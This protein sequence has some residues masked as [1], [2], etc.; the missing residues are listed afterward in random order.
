MPLPKLQLALSK[1]IAGL[2]ARDRTIDTLRSQLKASASCTPPLPTSFTPPA[3]PR[4][5][6]LEV[7]KWANDA[8]HC[9]T[10]AEARAKATNAEVAQLVKASKDAAE[11]SAAQL[12]EMAGEL[13]MAKRKAAELSDSKVCLQTM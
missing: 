2:K 11:V 6:A 3:G 4:S 7:Q 1:S 9:E 8:E 5:T 10:Q 12:Q 13:T